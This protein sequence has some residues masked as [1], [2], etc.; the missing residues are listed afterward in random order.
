MDYKICDN[1]KNAF[2]LAIYKTICDIISSSK[3][4]SQIPFLPNDSITELVD[5]EMFEVVIPY[6]GGRD[7]SIDPAERH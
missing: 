5:S 2:Y 1:Y 6:L 3:Q 7:K 4:S